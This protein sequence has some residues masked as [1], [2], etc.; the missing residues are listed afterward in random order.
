MLKNA[1]CYSACLAEAHTASLLYDVITLGFD[2][3]IVRAGRDV[4]IVTRRGRSDALTRYVTT[5][6][7][8]FI[9]WAIMTS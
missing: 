4:L 6:G 9:G 1:V 2:D 8:R 5:S 3:V 7:R